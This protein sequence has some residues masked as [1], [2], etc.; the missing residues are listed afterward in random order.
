MWPLI[1][2]IAYGFQPLTIFANCSI[3][4]AWQ[5]SEYDSAF[6]DEDLLGG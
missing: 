5:G 6:D 3:L 2:W 4:D 1:K